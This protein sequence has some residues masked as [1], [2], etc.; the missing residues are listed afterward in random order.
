MGADSIALFRY[1]GGDLSSHDACISHGKDFVALFWSVRFDDVLRDPRRAEAWLSDEFPEAIA[2]HTDP[3]GVFLYPDVVE[4]KSRSYAHILKEVG[5]AG[6]WLHP[7]LPS[8]EPARDLLLELAPDARNIST[9]GTPSPQHTTTPQMQV[10][11]NTRWPMDRLVNFY[12]DQLRSFGMKP[13]QEKER[14]EHTEASY[15]IIEGRLPGATAVICIE[16]AD[17]KTTV[18]LGAK[19]SVRVKLPRHQHG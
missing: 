17:T 4:P 7:T 8:S 5:G 3:R 16:I 11:F 2:R 6:T 14:F 12:V 18:S 13:R 1:V 19:G 10:T 15:V 9:L